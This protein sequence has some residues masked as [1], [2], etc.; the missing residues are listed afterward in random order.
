MKIADLA[1][2][3]R[4]SVP[5]TWNRIRKEGLT[6]VKKPAENMKEVT[7]VMISDDILTKYNPDNFTTVNNIDNN[8]YY[9]EMLSDNNDNKNHNNGYNIPETQLHSGLSASEVFERLTTINNDYNNRLQTLSNE[10]I[11]AKSKLLLLEDKANREG[12]YLNEINKLQKANSMLNKILYAALI[13]FILILL[14]MTATGTY[15]YTM[16]FLR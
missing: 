5:T 6:T 1:L 14:I 16:N 2:F 4:V 11:D 9:K 3:W 15:F 10:V 7:F 8:D 13:C 12:M